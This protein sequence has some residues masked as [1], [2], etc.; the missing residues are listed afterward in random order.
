M[1]GRYRKWELSA[2]VLGL[3]VE[4]VGLVLT[5]VGDRDWGWMLVLGGVALVFVVARRVKLRTDVA[6][7]LNKQRHWSDGVSYRDGS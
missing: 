6:A 1:R 4:A 7:K 2:L 5:F 3:V